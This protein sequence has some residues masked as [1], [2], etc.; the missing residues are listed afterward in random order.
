MLSPYRR[1]LDSCPH[2]S[3]GQ[4]FTLCAC[5]IWAYGRLNGSII[6]QSVRT[7]DWQRALQRIDNWERGTEASPEMLTSVPTL[8]VATEE[9]RGP[10]SNMKEERC[11]KELFTMIDGSAGPQR[12]VAAL[13]STSA[14]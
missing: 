5:P 14:E 11:A 4:H 1:H 9:L 10:P 2:R 6:R 13:A 7:N 12:D 3:R 8:A